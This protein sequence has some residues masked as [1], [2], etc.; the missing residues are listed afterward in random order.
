[1]SCN[2]LILLRTDDVGE[3]DKEELTRTASRRAEVVTRV[4]GVTTNDVHY[5]RTDTASEHA[6]RKMQSR[7]EPK[8]KIMCMCMKVIEYL[9]QPAVHA[10]RRC[11]IAKGYATQRI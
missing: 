8:N 2:K 1:M 9:V 4:K 3:K 5:N 7:E 10:G 11:P 6:N